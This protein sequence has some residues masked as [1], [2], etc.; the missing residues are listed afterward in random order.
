M[1]V[2]DLGADLLRTMRCR[3]LVLSA[4]EAGK[5]NTNHGFVLRLVQSGVNVIATVRV[6]GDVWSFYFFRV[7]IPPFCPLK[8]NSER[9]CFRGGRACNQF[10]TGKTC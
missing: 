2:N 5:W 4:C 1:T 9:V 10:Q 3:L 8:R 6:V 7:S